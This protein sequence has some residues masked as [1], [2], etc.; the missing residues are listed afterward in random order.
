MLAFFLAQLETD[1][2][3]DLFTQYYV[4]HREDAIKVAMRYLRSHDLAEDAAQSGW[5]KLIENFQNFVQ[6]D[7]QKR[8]PYIVSIMKT[9]AIDL[10]RKE[11]RLVTM[12]A[13]DEPFTDAPVSARSDHEALVEMVRQLPEFYREVAERAFLGEQS[14]REIA[15]AMGLS[16]SAVSRRKSKAVKHLRERMEKEGYDF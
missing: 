13:A 3:R 16:E 2:E 1:E 11:K 6:F 4:E 15:K 5:Q 7:P 9:T 10:L 14:N 12:E 8:W